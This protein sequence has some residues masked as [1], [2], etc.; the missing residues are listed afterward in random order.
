MAHLYAG[1]LGLLAF[2]T[3]LARGA[4]HGGETT[5]VL[6][7]AWCCLLAFSAL[8]CA[9]GWIAEMTVEESVRSRI[10]AE[11]GEKEAAEA[12]AGGTSKG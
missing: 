9:I 3:S 2:L 4:L 6:L 7:T 5:S 8:G 11:L 12:A 10:S 1:I